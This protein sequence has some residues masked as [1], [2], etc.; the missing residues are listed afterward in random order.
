MPYAVSNPQLC[1]YLHRIRGKE[2]APDAAVEYTIFERFLYLSEGNDTNTALEE[3]R[4]Q[5]EVYGDDQ[6][7]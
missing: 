2:H 3:R 6:D 1:M 5:E 4:D 7:K